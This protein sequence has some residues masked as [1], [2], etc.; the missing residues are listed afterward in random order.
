ME[1]S[2]KIMDQLSEINDKLDIQR[3]VI[4]EINGRI[5]SIENANERQRKQR[6]FYKSIVAAGII[7]LLVAGAGRSESLKEDATQN[8]SVAMNIAYNASVAASDFVDRAFNDTIIDKVTDELG[9][10]YDNA[11]D[12]IDSI[13][14]SR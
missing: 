13:G 1:D 14:R 10:E 9:R 6:N 8:P 2:N 12:Y 11:S 5:R 3:I 7:G 4:E